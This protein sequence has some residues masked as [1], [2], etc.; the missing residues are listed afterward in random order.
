MDKPLN[1]YGDVSRPTEAGHGMDIASQR[2]DELDLLA[3]ENIAARMARSAGKPT[4]R[5]L[6][7]GCGH[8]GQA[9]RMARAGAQV[10]AIDVEDCAG[11]V[12]ARMRAQGV[13][14][15]RWA[16]R[17]MGIEDVG[18]LE[19]K[20]DVCVCQRMIHYL[21]W[22]DALRALSSLRRVA[23]NGAMLYLSASGLDSELG[24]GYEGQ[25]IDLGRR[26]AMLRQDRARDH[27]IHVPVCLYRKDELAAL[28]GEAGWRTQKAFRS[29]FGNV[30]LVASSG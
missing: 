3:V 4:V 16:F 18:S 17:Q 1:T 8:G 24:D 22:G 15:G 28:A 12:D 9:A 25:G 10:M 26:F 14:D 2:A 11:K 13:A 27:A 7:I 29:D 5:A 19:F 6:D 30:K 21:R 23:A 20:V